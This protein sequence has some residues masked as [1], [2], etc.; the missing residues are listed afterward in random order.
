MA[1]LGD[2][3]AQ[4]LKLV[5]SLEVEAIETVSADRLNNFYIATKKGI[6]KQYSQDNELKIEFAPQKA[7]N[8]TLVEAWNPLRIF[9]FYENFQEYVLLDRFLIPSSRYDMQA[10]TAYAGLATIS[11]D[12]NLWLVDLADFG[13]KKYNNSFGQT[14]INTS[15]DLLL[16]PDDYEIS[17]IREYQNLVFIADKKSGILVFDNMGNFLRKIGYTDVDYFNFLDREIY[18]V[19]NNKLIFVNIYNNEIR[20]MQLPFAPQFAL[21][22]S[23]YVRLFDDKM[24]KIYKNQAKN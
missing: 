16:D 10:I 15:F 14:I 4:Q 13:L 6:L 8:I 22:T 21:V 3:K 17:F 9:I 19:E 1:S 23:N 18:F 24:V 12:N 5:D 11:A 7:G 20:T 2:L